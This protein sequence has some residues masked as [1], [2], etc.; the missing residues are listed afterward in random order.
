MDGHL[1]SLVPPLYILDPKLQKSDQ[2]QTQFHAK[3]D[4]DQT[5][6][7]LFPDQIK[8][9]QTINRTFGFKTITQQFYLPD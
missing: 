8:E 2:K 6:L 4:L 3:S 5:K 9:K 1:S 7:D